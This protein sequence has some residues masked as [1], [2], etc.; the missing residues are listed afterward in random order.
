MATEG[1]VDIRPRTAGEILDDAWRLALA[2]APVLVLLGG[3][4]QVPAFCAVLLL[5]ARP[6]PAG[7]AQCLLPALAALLAAL[8]GLGSG[9][10]Q[11]WLRRRVEG[12]PVRPAQCL[13]LAL[14]HGP[15]HVAVRAV[16]LL[17]LLPC[18]VCLLI[19]GAGGVLLGLVCLVMPGLTVWVGGTSAH[20]L[21]VAGKGRLGA[22]LREQGREAAFAPGKAAAVTLSRLPLLLLA[23]VNLHLL[24]QVGLWA[25][26]NPGGLDTALAA[27]VM[28]PGN[29]VYLV[30]LV[31]LC[32]LLLAPYAEAANFLLH[33]DTRTRQEGLDLLY[34][35][36]RVFA[37]PSSGDKVTADLKM[38]R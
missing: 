8:T 11:E 10:C 16:Q 18:L 24:A 7:P 29:P 9:A 30:A 13:A 4:F 32:W 35:V 14:R 1:T 17:G 33:L 31:L 19:P 3:L 6:A 28:S 26:A 23:A 27:A 2:D 36:Q 15:G 34:R 12:K 37:T 5:L 38:T 25:A 22:A 21:L 20:A